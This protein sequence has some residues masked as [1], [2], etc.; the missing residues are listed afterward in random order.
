MKFEARNKKAQKLTPAQVREIRA[1]YKEGATQGQLCRYFKVSVGQIGRIVRGES[2][3]EIE[4][5]AAQMN[6][7]QLADA[8][9]R[10]RA[11]A[12]R[13]QAMQAARPDIAALAAEFEAMA[14]D[15]SGMSPGD[16]E[17]DSP[18]PGIQALND[19]ARAMGVDIEELRR[20]I[21]G[22][23]APLMFD[24]LKEGDTK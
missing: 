9:E 8:E 6:P 13:A 19:R 17:P 16:S 10:L 14:Q 2:W 21:T 12:A 5:G 7:A 3:P 1:A 4:A 24:N 22:S 20:P 18:E 23:R 11:Q 15:T